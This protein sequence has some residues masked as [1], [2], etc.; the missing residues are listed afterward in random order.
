MRKLL[1]VFGAT[2]QQGGSLLRGLLKRP[3]VLKTYRLRGI[4]RDVNKA[5]A[6]ALQD[7]G[8]EMV[9]GDMDDVPSLKI[10]LAGSYAVFAI[11]NYWERASAEV[12]INQGKAMADA[13]V[14][15]GAELIIWSSLPD[16]TAMSNGKL[17]SVKHFDSKAKVESYIR[18]L[19]IKSAFFWPGF[20]MQQLTTMFK[21]KPNDEGKLTFS[22][23]WGDTPTP[24]IDI[25]DTAKYL[26]PILLHP[27]KYNGKR[28]VASTAYYSATDIVETF[29]K[30]IGKDMQFI[31]A[32]QG[33]SVLELPPE[34]AQVLK[35]SSGL[36]A[37]FKF[38][39]P[40]GPKDLEWTLAQM[41][42]P[43]TTFEDFVRAN[44]R[45]EF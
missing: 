12:E 24:M 34:I 28:F 38:Y 8:V 41:D 10:A 42:D 33:S 18:D 16:V 37:E 44:E 35:E 2:G 11:T 36:M 13:A 30:V 23:S 40:S 14:A 25:A 9:Q 19:P 7:A 3:D 31:Q 29:K 22:W 26:I 17:T 43:P 32:G 1:S 15:A 45:W 39:G 20:F 21:P 5:S 4:T 27:D 6:I